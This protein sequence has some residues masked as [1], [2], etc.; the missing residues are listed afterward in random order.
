MTYN[1]IVCRIKVRSHPNADR[2]KI[3]MAA[4]HQVVVG[5]DTED[6]DLGVFFPT[7]GQLSEEFCAANRLL[8]E[9]DDQGVLVHKGYFDK[10]RRVRAQSLRGV[11]SDGF[12]VP[13]SYFDFVNVL[14]EKCGGCAPLDSSSFF[15]EGTIF[16]SIDSGYGQIP[17]CNKYFTEQ[18][19]AARV[20]IDK[21]PVN[22]PKHK[23]TENI[24]YYSRSIEAGDILTVTRKLHG[25]SGRLGH[26]EVD[27]IL[28]LPLWKRLIN[29]VWLIF[30]DVET[31]WQHVI[32]TRN[33]VVEDNFHGYYG[34]SQF[35]RDAVAG[36]VLNKGEIIYYELV[37]Y[38]DTGRPIMDDHTI[39]DNSLKKLFGEKIR[40]S[41]GC[42]PDQCKLFVYRITQQALN[43]D[44]IELSWPQ[45]VKRCRSL[46]LETVPYL[47][48][49]IFDD[50]DAGLVARLDTY[51]NGESGQQVMPEPLDDSHIA[52]GV[53][54]R[55]DGASGTSFFKLKS[56][57][58][59]VLEGY[60]KDSA[61]YVDMEEAS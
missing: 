27:H 12:W 39:A 43:G 53:V 31:K 50:D 38:T 3:G 37:G 44:Q 30:P 56:W 19:A 6:N 42:Q 51:V 61:T 23:D 48:T 57:V 52:E 55:V 8:S 9:Y 21:N 17:I 24:K 59:G 20:K 33:V 15:Y 18:T 7:D 34:Q 11:R 58:F 49:E 47:W 26:V 5:I 35:R 28:N 32:G 16:S 13:L 25:T 41:Y 10:N 14:R 29:K 4:G 2:L 54:I 1:A 36:I 40:Y 45:V 60:I 46:G 22:F